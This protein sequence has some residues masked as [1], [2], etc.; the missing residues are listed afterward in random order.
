LLT[1]ISITASLV[2]AQEQLDI[3]AL[4][5][6]AMKAAAA[7][8]AD[9]VVRIETLGGREKVDDVLVGTGPTTGVIVSPDGYILSSAF[10]FIQQPASILVTL[11]GGKRVAAKVVARDQSR[12]LVLLKAQTDEMLPTPVVAPRESLRVGQWTIALGRTYDGPPTVSVGVLSALNRIWGKAVQTDA[13]ISPSN[14]GGPLIDLHGRAI[15]ILVP[16][17]PFEQGEVAGAEWYDSG[18][19]FAIPL[20]DVLPRLEEMKQGRDLSPGLLGVSLKGAD[21]YAD[22]PVIAAVPAKSPAAKAGLKVGDKIAEID[23][24]PIVRQAQLK[25]ALGRRY[26]LDVVRIAALRGDERIEVDVELAAK[27]EPYAHPFLGVLP[28]RDPPADAKGIGVRYVYAGS[29]ADKAGITT[30][31]RLL[32]IDGKELTTPLAAQELLAAYEPGGK[33]K[34]TLAESG[35]KREVEVSLAALPSEAPGE[36]PAA[37][38]SEAALPAENAPAT[39]VV[40][41]KLPEEANECVA[42]VPTSYDGQSPHGLIVWLA[43][44][45]DFNQE[46][47]VERWRDLCQEHRFILLAPQ[48][49]D[50]ARWSPTEVDFLGK[51]IDN[52]VANYAID[53]ARIVAHGYQAGGAMAYLVAFARRD[54][55]R[56][57]APIDAAFPLRTRPPEND[58][59]QRLAIYAGVAEKSKLAEPIQAA[60]DKLREMKFPVTVRK[61]GEAR[62][63]NDEE[64]AELVRWADAL[65][66]L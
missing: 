11:P 16:L 20:A 26:A 47:L 27:I 55:V 3:V 66:R 10:N 31:D 18:I 36:L 60:I 12:M 45:G 19:G 57:V 44:P 28:L 64:L 65:D 63:L 25:H 52:V 35:E 13:K 29:P 9:W 62:Y 56:G 58:P 17:S 42:Y 59:V 8:A 37:W 43:A 41:I 46:K 51:A 30:S 2:R 5:E 7:R 24:Q 32:A 15:G 40:Q 21:I 4:E 6:A 1:V 50:K 49:L 34:V 39:G 48:P 33:V 54:V 14:Y 53:K 22:E 38:S 23:G 61:T